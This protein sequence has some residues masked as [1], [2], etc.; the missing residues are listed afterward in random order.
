MIEFINSKRNYILSIA[1][2]FVFVSL[3][4]T[5]Y[6]LFLKSDNTE[7]FTYN[8]G[9]L[10]LQFVED[11]PLILQDAFPMNDSDATRLEPYNLTIKN[12]GNVTYYFDLK[13]VSSETTNAIDN[14]Y[15]KF[16]VNDNLSQ[17]LFLTDNVIISNQVIYPGEEITYK[18]NIWLDINT[19]NKELGKK[20]TAKVTT[21]GNSIYKTL[22]SSGANSPKLY[23][24]ML[25]VYYDNDSKVWKK[26]DKANLDETNKW[27]DYNDAM[28][29]NVVTIK[30]SSK[31]IYDIKRNN[32]LNITNVK[33]NNGNIIIENNPLDINLSNYNYNNITNIIRIKFNNINNDK[34]N[35]ISNGNISYYYD[36]KNNNFVFENEGK[37][38]NSNKFTIEKDKWYI[39]GYTYDGNIVTFYV[40][41]TNLGSSNI[42]G[43]I[44]S[45]NSF[46]LGKNEN[47][48]ITI[49][50]I[51]IYNKILSDNIFLENYKT[52]IHIVYDGLLC[53]YDEFI[54]MTLKEYYLSRNNG[55]V[56]NEND[57]SSFYVWIPRYKYRLFNIM[58]EENTN[59]YNALNN[60][61]DIVFEKDLTS[62]GVIYCENNNC[63][64]NIDKT[65][66][67]TSLDNDKYYTHK[68]F[69]TTNNELSGIW[70]SK[71]E[72]S[73]I[74]D[75]NIESKPG[76]EVWRNNNLSNYYENI[77]KIST[78]ENYSIIK[79]TEWGAI[80]YLTY[81]KYGICKDKCQKLDNNNTY[82]SG[83]NKDDSTTKNI[84]GVYDMSG[85][86]SEYTMSNITNNGTLNI[87]NSNFKNLIIDTDDYELYEKYTFILGDATKEISSSSINPQY[88]W[89]IRGNN[90]I[91]S[92]STSNDIKDNNLTTRIVI[93]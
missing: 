32:D 13:M 89:I 88:E 16:K 26:A 47:S 24:N 71:Y 8:T 63:F 49:G 51:L 37:I 77:K 81:S 44:Y 34:I 78:E 79:N 80:T 10:D 11:T 14:R 4:D 86:A 93:R 6:S 70:V 64:S 59:T 12:T 56:I 31:K 41:G 39:L 67:I 23:Q 29:A 91:F 55:F 69:S 57:I 1:L 40:D 38:V 33:Y 46:K 20:F 30:D 17:N 43:T 58:G 19:P 68:A 45:N 61:I 60:G 2:L 73:L 27:Y 52:S 54:P 83:N 36:N 48:K 18:I 42:Q 5:T 28:W 3:S 22:D 7:E 90:N 35:I 84:Y 50:T 85:S 82:I 21:V 92:Y 25:Q 15:I 87:D 9:I 62:S 75:N 53:G 66:N 74:S 72:V 76:T 65:I